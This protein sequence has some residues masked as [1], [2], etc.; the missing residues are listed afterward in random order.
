MKILFINISDIHGGSAKAAYRL[1]R[2]LEEHYQTENLFLVRTKKTNDKN[3]FQTRKSG[4]QAF[5]ERWI[6]I[7]MNIM[8]LQ[9]QW[10]PFSPKFILKKAKEFKPDVI[11][12]HNTIGGYFRTKDLIELSQIAPILWTLHDMWAFTR[13]GAH[14]FGN[15]SWKEL[16][17]FAGENIIYPWIKL[18]SGVFLLKQKK[19]IVEHSKISVI[20]P[21]K[22][23]E[24]LVKQ[25]P[26]FENKQ[27]Y[28]IYNG[29]DETIFRPY[30]EEENYSLPDLDRNIKK[31]MFAGEVVKGSKWKGGD[32]LISILQKLDNE[33]KENVYFILLGKKS[34]F[35]NDLEL[36]NIRIIETGYVVDEVKM[37]KIY[38][39]CDLLIYPTKADNLPTVLI[40]A[41]LCGTPCLSFDVGG[42]KEIISDN[43]N[44]FVFKP[45]EQQ[46]LINKTLELL[47]NESTLKDLSEKTRQHTMKLFTLSR[48][49]DSYFKRFE[50]YLQK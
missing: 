17:T 1:G 41:T 45:D 10:L 27:I 44:G 6:N 14:T 4:F 50:S 34:G 23:L 38:S 46:K 30:S 7:F 13:N 40:E 28:Q 9:Y 5:T 8:G 43:N 47:V 32:D 48:M 20:T 16:K 18:N 35:E 42:V 31:I 36:K 29:V 39:K 3:V 2:Y 19:R 22:W 26:V 25:S 11:S 24:G 12:L 21:S 33:L 15:E 37:A 49:G